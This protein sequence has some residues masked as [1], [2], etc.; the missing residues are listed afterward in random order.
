[1]AFDAGAIE[2]RVEIDLSQVDTDLRKFEDKVRQFERMPHHIRISALVDPHELARARLQFARLDQQITNDARQRA[3]TGGGSLLGGLA[4]LFGG[5]AGGGAPGTPGTTGAAS[6][7]GRGFFGNLLGGIGPGIGPLGGLWAGRL[8]LGA[9]GLGAL[10]GAL[11]GVLPLGVGLAG[12]GAAGALFKGATSQVSPLVALQSSIQQAQLTATTP[13]QLKAL[14]SQTASL[15]AAVSKL[16]PAQQSLFHTMTGIS[17]WWQS[18]SG[19]FQGTFAKILS[20]IPGILHSITPGLKSFFSGAVTIIRPFLQGLGTIARI[21][22]PLLG[23]AFRIVAPL[24]RPL[25]DGLGHLLGGLLSGLLPLLRAARP[26]VMVLAHLFGD[27]GGSIGQMFRVMAPA[28]KASSVILKALGLVLNEI[29][30]IVGKLAGIMARALAPIFLSLAKVVRSLLPVLLII[31]KI[32]ASLAGAVLTDLVAAFG[33]LAQLLHLIS[34]GLQILAKALGNVFTLLENSGIFAILGNALERLVPSLAK[35]I[36]ALII[37]LVPVLPI[38]IRFF[39]ELV[40]ALSSGIAVILSGIATALAAIISVIPPNVLSAIAIAILAIVAGIKL[41]AIAQGALDLLF[42]G[43]PLGLIAIA[44]GLIII[45]V[46]ELV[47]HWSTIWAWMKRIAM[48]FGRWL[49]TDFGA[50]ILHFFTKDIPIAFDIFKNAVA[51]AW[52]AIKLTFLE[53]AYFITG[54]MA[55]LPGPLGDPFKKAHQ[56][57]GNTMAQIQADIHNHVLAIKNDFASLHDKKVALIFG[58]NLPAGVSFP[59]RPIKGHGAKG[60]KGAAAGMW[61]V[62]EEGPEVAWLPQGTHV[63]PAGPSG[64]ILGGL[65][66]GTAGWNFT[67]VFIPPVAAYLASLNRL[68]GNAENWIAAQ[69]SKSATFIPPG[70]GG[71]GGNVRAYASLIAMALRMLGQPLRDLG[72]VESQMQTESGGNPTIVNKWDSNWLAGHPSVGLMQVIQ[73]TFDAFAGPFRNLGP[74]LYGVSVNPMAN[75]FAGLNY[76]VHRYGAAWTSV[77]GH[78]HGY[79]QGGAV[80]EPVIGFGRSG[81]MYSFAEN[82]TEWVTP[83][84]KMGRGPL[85]G[86]LTLMLPEGTSVASALHELTFRLKNVQQMQM[87][88]MP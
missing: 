2:A 81:R 64:K 77:L 82:E 74:F 27:L 49:W 66:T 20:V 34:P 38:V 18:F 13:A 25:L 65:A 54:V 4:T 76:A 46:V 33:A 32:F 55:K 47:K 48:D 62:G 16:N 5:G 60:I 23:Q 29:F 50:K 80:R 51:I 75:I 59:S 56:D 10:P 83:Q 30:P 6:A 44:V 35:L 53:G 9:A 58:L 71:V 3:R 61:V 63:M 68:V 31:G 39:T 7:G 21:A 26:A 1:V 87:A 73:G 70:I 8:G 45:A 22:L 11:G 14:A 12:L 40:T 37:G 84:S 69:V 19:T 36:N 78:G 52:D 24:M 42:A 57:I 86:S 43:N 72:I 67:D 41:W 15:N 79:S 88:V 28:V 17:Q 85:I